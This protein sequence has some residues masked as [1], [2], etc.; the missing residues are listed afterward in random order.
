MNHS[1]HEQ[2][3]ESGSTDEDA[4]E[5][6]LTPPAV[7]TP[8]LVCSFCDKH[9]HWINTKNAIAKPPSIVGMHLVKKNIGKCTRRSTVNFARR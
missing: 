9:F 5:S 1:S 3:E 8:N 7:T 6:T 2:P 4:T